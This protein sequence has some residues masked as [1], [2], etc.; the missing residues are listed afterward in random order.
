MGL[1][2]NPKFFLLIDKIIRRSKI[3]GLA[4]SIIGLIYFCVIDKIDKK[5][6]LD[7]RS[8]AQFPGNSTL[9]KK[10]EDFLNETNSYFES[11]EYKEGEHVIDIVHDYI[12]RVSSFVD[13]EKHEIK[14]NDKVK[15]NI[16]ISNVGCKFCNNI[17]NLI[18]VINFDYKERKYF[19]SLVV[20]L[21]LINYF[22]NAN[23]MSKDIIFL[24]TNKELLYS[25]GVQ[26]FIEHYYYGNTENRKVLTR[27]AIIIEFESIYPSHIEINYESLNGML[28]NQDLILLLRNELNHYSVPIKTDPVYHSI[29]NVALEKK[30][31]KGHIYFLRENIPSFTITGASKVPL[32]RKMINLFNFTKSLQSFLRSQ[33]NTHEGFCHSTNFYFFN[34]IK[35][36]VPISLYV[37]CAYL[38]G[39]YCILK[40]IKGTIFRNY[41]NFIVGIY[42]YIITILT[43]S[44]PIYLFSTNEKIYDLIKSE[45][46]LPICTEWH[47]DNFN[48]YIEISN[49]WLRIFIISLFVAFILNYFISWVIYKYVKIWDYEK[50]RKIQKVIILDKIKYLNN[51]LYNSSDANYIKKFVNRYKTDIE[52]I[53]KEN[54]LIKPKVIHSDDED[55]VDAKKKKRV[56]EIIHEINDMEKDLY[57]LGDEKFKYILKNTIAPY[58][59]IMNHANIFYF[60][61]VVIVSSM[62]N[63]A[64][65]ILF[66]IILVTPVSML[67]N[68]KLKKHKMTSKIIILLFI[69]GALMYLYPFGGFI[70]GVRNKIMRMLMNFSTKCLK[71][72]NS[73]G[74]SKKVYFPEFL[75]FICSNKIFDTLYLNKYYLDNKDIKFNYNTDISNNVLLNLYS[76]ARNHYCIGSQLYPLLCFTFFPILFYITFIFFVQ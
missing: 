27:S 64:Y 46:R 18:V 10:D 14:I 34:T 51:L 65:S 68:I 52:Y 56:I 63:W 16:L 15:D 73:S 54:K 36:Y 44:M 75:E 45:K 58:N 42:M 72:M 40:L 53:N 43:I 23:Y 28:P 57:L 8:F 31:E 12:K 70:L 67:H 47:P 6:E 33:S 61:F 25:L 32:K 22:L 26:K 19:H 59:Y 29:L 7:A 71:C 35:K 21:T 2:E 66:C 1:S 30:Y 76:I 50:D 69:L 20:G 55:F 3:I 11:Y 60:L 5:A 38:I 9:T 49:Y 41:V 48:K 13:T 37:F 17:E 39:S 62:Y 24:F 74:L 4:L